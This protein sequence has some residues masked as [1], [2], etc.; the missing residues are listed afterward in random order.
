VIKKKSPAKINL[1]LRVIGKRAD[2]Y[3]NILSL[4]QMITLYDELVFSFDKAGIVLDCLQ[5][6]LPVDKKNLVYRAAAA[7]YQRAGIVPGIKITLHKHIP[8]GAG[9]GGGSSNAATTLIALNEI[10]KTRLTKRELM[11]IG[12]TLGAD[13]PFFIFGKTAWASGRGEI[14]EEALLLP[15]LWFVM[16]NPGFPVS[17]KEIYQS[18]NWGLTKKA[19]NYSIP[20]FST[21]NEIAT[22]L[23]NDLEAVTLALY[24]VLREIKAFLMENGALGAL[25]TG[26]GP[27]V[28][29]IFS[30]EEKAARAERL[31]AG[32][33]GWLAFVA[34]PLNQ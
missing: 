14:L 25:M 17:T 1:Y 32:K 10:Y 33:D 13:V 20:R 22:G 29:G 15:P 30:S 27:T 31:S 2:G 19:I 5:S 11:Q 24:P 34:R 12:E 6:D 21:P 4:M 7:F 16:I 9:L 28:F 8:V 18:L 23:T 3:H 26:S